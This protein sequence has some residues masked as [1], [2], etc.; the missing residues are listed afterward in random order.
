MTGA[1]RKLP[2]VE[3][4]VLCCIRYYYCDKISEGNM[5]RTCGETGKDAYMVLM[6]K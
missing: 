6:G 5:S 2:Y 1:W 3:L 4:H